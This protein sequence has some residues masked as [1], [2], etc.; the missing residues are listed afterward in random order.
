MTVRPISVARP[1]TRILIVKPSSLGDILHAFPLATAL[2]E[3]FPKARIDWV[4]NNEFVPLIARHPAIDRVLA[5]PRRD[6][7]R[8]SFF[9]KMATLLSA[10]RELPYDAVLDAQGLLR[11][12]LLA[13]VARRSSGSAP[14][15]GFQRAREGAPLF[16]GQRVPI[17]ETPDAPLH[18]VWRNLL[19]LEALG[20]PTTLPSRVPALGLRY[21][22][23]DQSR[24]TDLLL[25]AGLL[26]GEPFIAIHPGARRDSKRWPSAYFSELIR[27]LSR[28]GA[29]RA[30]LVGDRSEA[31]LLEEIAVRTGL[32]VPLLPGRLPLD[33]LPLALSRAILFIGNDSGPLHMAALAGIPTLSFFGSSDPRRT[34]PFGETTRNHVMREALPCSPCGD[35]R[36]FCAHM[37]CQVSLTPGEAFRQ[38]LRLLGETKTTGAPPL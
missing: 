10:L 4:A 35:F 16:Y 25:E 38:A 18:A 11:S 3:A 15:L 19:F 2:K 36:K 5:F 27:N 14:L 33:L 6:F 34:G 31:P 30:V 17:P 7:G 20:L 23:T 32:S 28:E 29:P 9:G 26:P 12:A 13:R 24:V 22:D 37:T 8:G 1:M 21:G